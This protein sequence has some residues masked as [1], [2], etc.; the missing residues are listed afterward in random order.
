MWGNCRFGNVGYHSAR[1]ISENGGKIV[2]VGEWNG[3]IFNEKGLDVEE[4]SRY[5]KKNGNFQ[6]FNG[7]YLPSKRATE[8]LE[9]PCDVLIPAALEKQIHYEN[10]PRIQAKLIGEGANGPT[11]PRGHDYLISQGKVIIPDM[12]LNVG[13]VCVSYFEWL[14]N[15]AHV[16]FG[17][18]VRIPK[19]ICDI[20]SI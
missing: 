3:A 7:E 1:F 12:L 10:A 18:L 16:R 19:N 13:G 5:W 6:G 15:L 11:T 4:L 2:G 14:K 20:I 17:R 8:I 9:S